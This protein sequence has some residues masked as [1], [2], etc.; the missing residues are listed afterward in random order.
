MPKPLE[1]KESKLQRMECW[2]T[3]AGPAKR[4]G[5]EKAREPAQSEL[6]S[7]LRIARLNVDSQELHFAIP[8]H[9]QGLTTVAA[10]VGRRGGVLDRMTAGEGAR[11]KDITNF[12]PKPCKE[13]L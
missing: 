3:R 12:P 13:D 11:T 2:R 5:L 9:A 10:V 1:Y 8:C 4:L 7:S 6:H